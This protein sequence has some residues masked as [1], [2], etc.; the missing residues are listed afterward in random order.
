M[1]AI[2]HSRKRTPA[3]Q[4]VGCGEA[5]SQHGGKSVQ[6]W[7]CR[8]VGGDHIHTSAGKARQTRQ[9]PAQGCAFLLLRWRRLLPAG[10]AATLGGS[11]TCA[12]S[13]L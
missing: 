1:S 8:L 12:T 13:L 3:L 9:P 4:R 10:Y 5:G 7:Q 11:Q 2:A 6:A